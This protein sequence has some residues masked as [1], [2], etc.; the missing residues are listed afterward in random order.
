MVRF[1]PV[2][3]DAPKSTVRFT[4][5]DVDIRRTVATKI[6]DD[7]LDAEDVSRAQTLSFL[8]QKGYGVDDAT[9]E[10]YRDVLFE[11]QTSWVGVNQTLANQ[12][13]VEPLGPIRNPAV[14]KPV[15]FNSDLFSRRYGEELGI[16]DY[17]IA[18][19]DQKVPSVIGKIKRE[20]LPLRSFF[21]RIKAVG[22]TMP[23]IIASLPEQTH[24]YFQEYGLTGGETAVAEDLREEVRDISGAFD[25]FQKSAKESIDIADAL[26]AEYKGP[27]R[28]G[29]IDSIKSGDARSL[30]RNLATD[31]ALEMPNFL[32]IVGL[33]SINPNLGLTYAGLSTGAESY[34]EDVA[35]GVDPSGAF[36]SAV[37]DATAEVLFERLGT[38]G[39]VEKAQ[40]GA[41][42]SGV[43]DVFEA[44]AR[45]GASEAATSLVQDVNRNQFNPEN[46]VA[47]FLLG[48]VM[49]AGGGVAIAGFNGGPLTTDD[50]ISL[51]NKPEV[52]ENLEPSPEAELLKKAVIDGDQGA[53]AEY[54]QNVVGISEEIEPTE[55]PAQEAPAA[56]E[57]AE[58]SPIPE[59][60][61]ERPITEEAETFSETEDVDALEPIELSD[62]SKKI[63][64]RKEGL[65][66]VIRP[67]VS[68]T[69]RIAELAPK[70]S[71]RIWKSKQRAHQLITE[72]NSAAQ[73]FF[74]SANKV[75]KSLPKAERPA[76][77]SE[78]LN[79]EWD[80]LEARGI[81]GVSE[82]RDMFGKIASDLGIDERTMMDNYFRRRVKKYP[83][84][85]EYLGSQRKGP[86]KKAIDKAEKDKG[87]RLT[88]K[89]RIAVVK[90]ALRSGD[91]NAF[92]QQRT[93]DVVTPEMTEFYENPLDELA[94]YIIG[95]SRA[96]ALNEMLGV[97]IAEGIMDEFGE[98]VNATDDTIASLVSDLV[99]SGEVDAR[100]E[101]TLRDLLKS[102]INQKASGKV[103]KNL[104]KA[105]S[106]K[107]VTKL[108]TVATQM[109]G[110]FVAIGENNLKNVL[111]K[112]EVENFVDDFGNDIKL[113]L[114]NID[115][116]ALDAELQDSKRRLAERG[117]FMP[118]TLADLFEKGILL[119]STGQKWH[120]L[121]KKSPDKLRKLL[122]FKF[123]DEAFVDNV[124]SDL[125]N[126]VLSGD[127]KLALYGQMSQFHPTSHSEHI[128][129]YIDN[130]TWR[131][132]FF[133]QSF[134]WKQFD[135]LYRESISP[136]IDGMAEWQVAKADGDTAR[137][138]VA[139]DNIARGIVNLS[140]FLIFAKGGE[141][142][143]RQVYEEI[144]RKLGLEPP[145]E[146][147][148]TLLDTYLR[149][150]SSTFPAIDTFA[151]RQAIDRGSVKEY[152]EGAYDVPMPI[153]VDTI[154]WMIKH[155]QEK[156]SATW[157]KDI[158]WLGEY[159]WREERAK[160]KGG[161]PFI[162]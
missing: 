8:Q 138:E 94:M 154:D 147:P 109:T 128:K 79:G 2:D 161:S 155:A 96:I 44:F 67:F 5:S 7:S 17:D 59:I 73:P 65:K 105:V 133:L 69:T 6:T 13:N 130:P 107:Y 14:T 152:W 160:N 104:R 40:A 78:M 60:E 145:E 121:A 101:A 111:S 43:K 28:K 146:E 47:S 126:D 115:M 26:A 83:Q 120:S 54:N 106:V 41:F 129:F 27:F 87:R 127:V 63:L 25:A 72:R 55:A 16:T 46:I 4:P 158:P 149:E 139:S 132:L 85:L 82:L 23:E 113:S 22:K 48:G 80:K 119:R 131:P 84:L 136:L 114:Q 76:L 118:L 1:T 9:A 74:A 117:I 81:D 93:I 61:A 144:L 122:V 66:D 51:R 15:E 137:R 159:L 90:H 18:T 21:N 12:L 153:G 100:R 35:D 42:K 64:A 77:F 34:A 99:E 20:S 49:D 31:I 103:V 86:F 162:P 102:E 71:L 88:Q 110:A 68:N 24:L 151:L 50:I 52:L 134:A 124:I 157:K 98:T 56:E 32:T 11:G 142:V 125:Q 150:L 123:K 92:K 97:N 39:T 75:I 141:A 38:I 156:E 91:G 33:G 95:T 19:F 30:G 10:A 140:K 36:S 112:S 57:V 143:V 45:G 37:V 29:Y 108:K 70:L 53:L 3:G 135:R 58:P 62:R 148:P 89:E 116:E